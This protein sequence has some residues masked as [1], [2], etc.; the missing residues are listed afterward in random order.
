MNT[1]TST[2][3]PIELVD[4]KPETTAIEDT[5]VDARDGTAEVPV[6]PL[7]DLPRKKSLWV[8][9]K[10]ILISVMIAWSSIMDGYLV[11]SKLDRF[12]KA[13]C[14]SGIHRRQQ[15]L[16]RPVLLHHHRRRELRAGFGICRRLDCGTVGGTDHW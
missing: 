1:T 5:K 10:A 4:D 7:K 11:S 16:Y 14:S 13:D 12:G 3:Q 8:Y 2:L 9:K 15:A 6:S